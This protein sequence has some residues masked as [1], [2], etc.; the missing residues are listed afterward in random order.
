MVQRIVDEKYPDLHSIAI[1]FGLFQ[2]L[3]YLLHIPIVQM[4][5]GNEQYNKICKYIRK[6]IKDVLSNTYLTKK[7]KIY[8]LLFAVAPK[9]LRQVHA[10]TMK[11]RQRKDAV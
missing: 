7:N 8:L 9:G 5:K 6:H 1:R 10:W 4:Q 2:R 3:D 11:M